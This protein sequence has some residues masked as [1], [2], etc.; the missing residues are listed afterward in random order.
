MKL[1]II[2]GSGLDNP[3]IL[4][5][6]KEIQ[7][8]TP[9]GKPSSN[10]S[11]GLLGK[12]QV[13]IIA[14]HGKNHEITPTYVNNRANIHALKT[15][16][17]THIIA[18]TAVGSLK[19][20][21]GRGDF[22]ILSNFIDFT[23][24]RKTT[25]H[26]DFKKG[27]VHTVMAN[28]FSEF[29]RNKAIKACKELEIKHHTK[30]TVITIEGPRFSTRAESNMFR[31]WGADVINMSIAPEAA[32]AKEA[33]IE[34]AAIAM[35]TDYDCWK[36]DEEPVSWEDILKIFAKNSEKMKKL[37][38]KIANKLSV[39]NK[40]LINLKIRTVP[41]WPK[42]GIM[43]KDVTTLIKDKDGFKA[44]I[45]ELENR[46]K[47]MDI[48]L[49]AGIESRGFIIASALA[50][51]LNKGFILIRKKGKLPAETISEK[52]DLEYGTAE[53]EI[54]KD[55]INKGQKILLLDDLIATGGTIKAA[56]NLIEKLG[57][58][59]VECGFIVE[60]VELKGRSKIN[61]PIYTITE[62][63]GK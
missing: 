32:L 33:G 13:L 51:R 10:I 12:I 18:T 47:K 24:H 34:Y 15:Q 46:Y 19:E 6:Y 2:G 35:S 16:G 50:D 48:D 49:V 58:K 8:S 5:D 26:D 53:L 21:I 20:K 11:K 61:W 3:E 9:Y 38:I 52:Y 4:K 41:N 55:A 54:H 57:G 22:V 43:F 39:T 44:V 1:G 60:L 30:G 62:F 29:L 37:L 23:K 7:I 63:E 45:N 40:E 27:V 14:R 59:I 56:G 25:F 17:C 36:T 28:P 42:P 31:Q